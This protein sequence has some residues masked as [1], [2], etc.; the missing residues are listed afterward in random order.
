[1]RIKVSLSSKILNTVEELVKLIGEEEATKVIREI[2]RI[3]EEEK[4]R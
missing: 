4:R 2:I 3:L 1:M